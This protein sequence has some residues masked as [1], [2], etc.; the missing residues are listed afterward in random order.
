MTVRDLAVRALAL[1]IGF[2]IAAVLVA[3]GPPGERPDRRRSDDRDIQL[4]PRFPPPGPPGLA[5]APEAGPGGN[6]GLS[7]PGLPRGPRGGFG[8]L[9]GPP[10]G[11][12][13]VELLR[14]F[15]QDQNGWLDDAERLRHASFESDQSPRARPIACHLLEQRPTLPGTLL[16]DDR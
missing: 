5:D 2:Q 8:G 12:Q 16:R 10:G 4:P 9:D 7:E 13:T 6:R 15:D 1:A 3:Q 14:Q 11:A